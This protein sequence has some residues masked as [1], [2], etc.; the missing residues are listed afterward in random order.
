MVRGER[1]TLDGALFVFMLGGEEGGKKERER[2]CKFTQSEATS[3]RIN[4]LH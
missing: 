2:G 1:E 3:L 4:F